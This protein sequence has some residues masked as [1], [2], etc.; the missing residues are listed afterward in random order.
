L[1]GAERATKHTGAEL[2]LASLLGLKLDLLVTN[3]MLD[4]S[5]E[6]NG[7]NKISTNNTESVS[8]MQTLE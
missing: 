6:V 7:Y 2:I 8:I 1:L 5:I 3:S 4:F